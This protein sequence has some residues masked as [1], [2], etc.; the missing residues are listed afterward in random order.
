M[1]RPIG[2]FLF[3]DSYFVCGN[4]L[5]PHAAKLRF[6]NPVTYLFFHAME[7]YLKAFLQLKGMPEQEL[8][9]RRLGHDLVALSNRAEELGL[10]V[11]EAVKEVLAHA[12]L[13]DEPIEA[14]YLVP[15]AKH[16]LTLDALY[17]CC[18]NLRAAVR[19]DFGLADIPTPSKP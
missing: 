11:S 16:R 1:A 7:L 13:E 8:R 5:R 14:R 9:S 4:T 6:D 2:W 15:G 17:A 3:A 18:D 19:A 10:T 12:V